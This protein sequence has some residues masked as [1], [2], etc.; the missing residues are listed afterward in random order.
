MGQGDQ[1]TEP[2][3]ARGGGEGG[4]LLESFAVS[5]GPAVPALLLAKARA[6]SA[7]TS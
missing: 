3:P 5:N 1:G 6:T 2:G 7:S 4:V